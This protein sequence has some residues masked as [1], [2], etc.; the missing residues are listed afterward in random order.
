MVRSI[1]PETIDESN[2]RLLHHK[3]DDKYMVLPGHVEAACR[4]KT[5]NRIDEK[6]EAEVNYISGYENVA[7]GLEYWG[8]PVEGGT[9]FL[10]QKF[11]ER[12]SVSNRGL[13]ETN[14]SDEDKFGVTIRY[15]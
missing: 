5:M 1:N 14:R 10:V 3:A 12:Q 6:R 13:L 15:L 4:V 7:F 2:P 9:G 8:R 11:D